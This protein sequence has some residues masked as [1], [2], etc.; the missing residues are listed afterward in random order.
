[1]LNAQIVT[2]STQA[3][4]P[5]VCCYLYEQNALGIYPSISTTCTANLTYYFLP[6]QIAIDPTGDSVVPTFPWHDYL[7]QALFVATLEY[8]MDGRADT[9]GQKR[10]GMLSRIRNIANPSRVSDPIIPLDP[11][12][13]GTPFRD[14]INWGWGWTR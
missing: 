10:E 2:A 12:V 9:E 7:I 14:D 4:V 8:E 11:Q 13:F 1:M 5:E 3:T 6:A